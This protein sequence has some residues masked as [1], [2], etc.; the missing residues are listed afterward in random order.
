MRKTMA[1]AAAAALAAISAG[2]P[3]AAAPPAGAPSPPVVWAGCAGALALAAQRGTDKALSPLLARMAR[4]ALGRAKTVE[5]P[6]KLTIDQI[7]GVALSAARSFKATLAADAS[8]EAA[9]EKTVQVCV[10][11]VGKLPG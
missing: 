2:A 10:D 11:A 4:S 3:A 9:F 5:N 6:E 1:A 7:D 8:Q